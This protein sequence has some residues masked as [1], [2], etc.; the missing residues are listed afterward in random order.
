MAAGVRARVARPY[1]WKSTRETGKQPEA[2]SFWG[3]APK[4][5]RIVAMGS[6]EQPRLGYAVVPETPPTS[7]VGDLEEYERHSDG[8]STL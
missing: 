4:S 3:G 2:G 5:R 1:Q 7:V 6:R 8:V